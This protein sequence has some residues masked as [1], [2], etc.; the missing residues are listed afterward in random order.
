MTL[1]WVCARVTASSLIQSQLLG[2]VFEVLCLCFGF[3]AHGPSSVS[4][5]S[6]SLS[7]VC[8]VHIP[9]CSTLELTHTLFIVFVMPCYAGQSHKEVIV[10]LPGVNPI[11]LG[12]LGE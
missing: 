9:Y 8:P 3:L 6:R 1:A 4:P 5:S 11:L 10:L 12:L 2:K 7:V